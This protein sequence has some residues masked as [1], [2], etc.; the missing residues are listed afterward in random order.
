MYDRPMESSGD[1]ELRELMV[2][3]QA[4][5]H[6][7]LRTLYERTAPSIRRYLAR[8]SD[9]TKAQDLTQETFLQIHRARRTYRPDLPPLP[10]MFAIARHVGLQHVRKVARRITEESAGPE[11]IPDERGSG[12]SAIDARRDVER[13][14]IALP[15][16]D[17]EVVWLSD[18]MGLSAA[19][20]A[21]V[22][23]SSEGAVRVRVHRAHQKMKAFLTRSERDL[24]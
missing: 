17:R 18:Y 24:S 7:A 23:N 9:S 19:E 4:G 8:W 1:A 2:Q 11:L 5:N 6:D 3:Y 10:W 22:V 14:L 16:A 21:R 15:E 12:Q 13:A 20:V